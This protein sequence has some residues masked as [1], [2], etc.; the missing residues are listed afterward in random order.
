MKFDMLFYITGL[1]IL[2]KS[3]STSL[4]Y[5]QY[6]LAHLGRF[7]KISSSETAWPNEPKLGRK[8]LWKV[9]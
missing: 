7:K 6:F 4:F 5:R 8:H 2:F 9:F 1:S 3:T